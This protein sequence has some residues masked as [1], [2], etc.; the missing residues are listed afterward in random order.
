ENFRTEDKDWLLRQIHLM[1]ENHFKVVK[2][3][4]REKEWDF[5]MLVEIGLDRIHHGFW[6]YFDP[7]HPKYQPGSPYANATRDYYKYLDE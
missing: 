5:F 2:H 3:L 4:L 7:Q 1:T 6:K